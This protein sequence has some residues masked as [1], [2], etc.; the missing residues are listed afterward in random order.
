MNPEPENFEA[1]RKLLALKRHEQPP[2][3]YF[4]QLP[5]RILAQLRKEEEQPNFW[6]RFVNTFVLRPAFAFTLGFAVCAFFITGLTFSLRVN[7]AM[8]A[9]QPK[10]ESW[11]VAS[12]S[13]NKQ[14][15]TLHVPGFDEFAPTNSDDQPSLFGNSSVRTMPASFSLGR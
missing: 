7:P 5:G 13:P 1:L 9:S 3:G 8:I 12:S 2:P 10:L 14:P 15:I 4:D 6:T 11:E